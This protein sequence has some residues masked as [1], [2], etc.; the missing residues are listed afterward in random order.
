LVMTA[1][2]EVPVNRARGAGGEPPPRHPVLRFMESLSRGLDA[3]SEM[4]TWSM[5]PA[6]QAEA[7]VAS[8]AQRARLAELELR[9]LV[10]ADRNSVGFDAGATSTA[11]WLAEATGSTR[12]ACFR[13]VHLAHAL[14]GD[15]EATR[16]A[17]A[18]GAIDVER[19]AVVVHAVQALVH[20][21]DGLP[22]ETRLAAERHL[23][24]LAA[25]FDAKTLARLGKRLF[26]VM[27]P[28][29]ADAAEGRILAQ[30]EERARRLTYVTVHDN[31]D[32]TSEGRFRVPTLHARLLRKALEAL[33]SPRRIGERRMDPDSGKPV[34]HSTLL[35]YGFLELLERHLDLDTLP[36]GGGS[37]FTVVVTVA[38]ETLRAELGIAEVETGDRVSAGEARRLACRAG[39]IPMVLGGA[40]EPLDLG[41]ERRL[42]SKHQ[43][44]ALHHQYRGCAATNCDRPSAWTEA[45]HEHAWSKGG[46]T[47]LACGI[48]LCPPH[49]HM[50]DHPQSWDMR[51]VPTGGVR[52]TR[53]Q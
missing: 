14:D 51:R 32:G 24:D 28:D 4:P 16:R 6:E 15:F 23:L 40:S 5:T 37:P 11:A 38:L 31:G 35:G 41:R 18:A 36:G 1:V 47:D 34:P 9:V 43:R 44:I 49:H 8:R 52:F 29:A 12:A 19:A 13:D 21:H 27:C 50:A 10:S 2:V 45:H 42:F 7:L 22:N 17:L 46:R 39:I 33:S 25:R 30:E 20:E 26:E 3:L 53:R 48:P